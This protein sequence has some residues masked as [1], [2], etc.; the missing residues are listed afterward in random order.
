ML[1]DI[2][3]GGKSRRRDLVADYLAWEM[4]I[5]KDTDGMTINVFRNVDVQ[6]F[7]SRLA[8]KRHIMEKMIDIRDASDGRPVTLKE[9][10][11]A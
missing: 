8:G 9:I 11:Y 4:Q 7:P 3:I 1:L 5:P 10:Y 2:Y 6:K